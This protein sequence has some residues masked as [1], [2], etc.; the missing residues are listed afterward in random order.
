[1]CPLSNFR[2]RWLFVMSVGMAVGF[3]LGE[4]ANGGTESIQTLGF[5]QGP[6]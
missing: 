3:F 1:M 4:A 6:A 2:W 5:I